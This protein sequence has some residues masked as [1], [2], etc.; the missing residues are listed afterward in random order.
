MKIHCSFCGRAHDDPGVTTF[1]SAN[2]VHGPNICDQCVDT[3]AGICAERRAKLAREAAR[4]SVIAEHE[5]AMWADKG[6]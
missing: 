6:P 3:A 4:S 2:E 5:R 1:V